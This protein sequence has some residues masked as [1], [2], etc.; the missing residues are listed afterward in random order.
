MA[1]T[2]RGYLQ[3]TKKIDGLSLRVPANYQ[4]EFII[5]PKWGRGV[6]NTQDRSWRLQKLNYHDNKA[7]WAIHNFKAPLQIF[8][9]GLDEQVPRQTIQN[10]IDASDPKNT[11]YHLMADWSHSIG[12]SPKKLNDYHDMLLAWLKK[13]WPLSSS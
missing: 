4:D 5:Y 11:D 8:E 9:A 3:V 10:Y 7:L 2:S 1:H 12:D 13:N 6:E